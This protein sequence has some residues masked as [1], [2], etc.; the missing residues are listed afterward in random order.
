LVRTLEQTLTGTF[1]FAVFGVSAGTLLVVDGYPAKA[2]TAVPHYLVEVLE[3][4]GVLTEGQVAE[5]LPRLMAT[6]ELA[7]RVL[8]GEGLV[9]EEQVELG[10]RTQLIRQMQSLAA[11]PEETSFSYRGSFDALAGYGAESTLRLD[12]FPFVWASLR[13]QPPWGH[14]APALAR[15][16]ETPMR[17]HSEA[18]TGRFAFDRPQRETIDLLRRRRWSLDQLITAGSLPADSVQLLVYCLLLTKQVEL[19]PI[20]DEEDDETDADAVAATLFDASVVLGRTSWLVP[21]PDSTDGEVLSAEILPEIPPAASDAAKLAA[22]SRPALDDMDGP[23]S[24]VETPR[25]LPVDLDAPLRDDAE[26][27][28]PV[29]PGQDEEVWFRPTPPRGMAA[30]LDPDR[31][32]PRAFVQALPVRGPM[33]ESEGGTGAHPVTDER[34]GNAP[35]DPSKATPTWTFGPNAEIHTRSTVRM[36]NAVGLA[37]EAAFRAAREAA[38]GRLSSSAREAVPPS[39]IAAPPPVTITNKENVSG[40]H[41]DLS[42]RQTLRFAIDKKLLDAAMAPPVA[43][44]PPPASDR[45]DV[46][47]EDK[48]DDSGADTLGVDAAWDD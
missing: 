48:P 47:T 27:K 40:P 25:G 33:L 42:S 28:T 18:E 11:L 23:S 8:V 44:A 29:A 9:T 21:A 6:E 38:S 22:A 43:D 2:R 20:V 37:E 5:W 12:P 19:L 1:E 35:A 24:D 45:T 36:M 32:T 13:Q 3:Q 10:L 34:D 46:K 14:I 39:H 30:M 17:L 7:G 26:R 41:G 16:G 4:L 15:V 31:P